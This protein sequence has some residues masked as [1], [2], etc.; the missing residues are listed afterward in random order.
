VNPEIIMR[1]GDC[2]LTE[3]LLSKSDLS[4]LNKHSLKYKL[5]AAEKDYM[6]GV[7]LKILYGSSL[8]K[9]LVF[10]GGTAIHHCYLPQTRFSEDLD[11]LRW[12]NQFQ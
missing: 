4:I 12:T 7:V 10:K 2:I 6:L 5:A 8:G 9:K 3:V 11:S 1:N